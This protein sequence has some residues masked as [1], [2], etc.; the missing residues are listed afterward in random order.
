MRH[1]RTWKTGFALLAALFAI[2]AAAEVPWVTQGPK[3]TIQTL[4]I[5]ANYKSPRLMAE[6][7]LYES[8]QPYLLFPVPESGDTRIYFC[9][10][11]G[12]SLEVPAG[13]LNTY[14][15]FLHPR[16]IVVLGDQKYVSDQALATLDR[17]IP[18]VR[19]EGNDWKRIAEELTFMLNL[20]NKPISRPMQLKPAKPADAVENKEEI[21]AGT[22]E[23]SAEQTDSTVQELPVE[24]N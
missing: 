6:L 5:A 21:P 7:I 17:S 23:E 1:F 24:A 10:A 3:R 12:P 18:I 11:K 14:V 15:N 4:I 9:P 22:A 2:T 19:I 16:R 8:R 13:Q 20:S